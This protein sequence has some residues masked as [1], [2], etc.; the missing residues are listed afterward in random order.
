MPRS[1]SST[2]ST[3]DAT[4]SDATDSDSGTSETLSPRIEEEADE[5]RKESRT[6]VSKT[7]TRHETIEKFAKSLG[8]QGDPGADSK[9]AAGKF[10][11]NHYEANLKLAD[12][13]TKCLSIAARSRLPL[14]LDLA[15]EFHAKRAAVEKELRDGD[16]DGSHL[17]SLIYKIQENVIQL[18]NA[19]VALLLPGGVL[20]TGKDERARLIALEDAEISMVVSLQLSKI[21]DTFVVQLCPGAMHTKVVDNIRSMLTQAA[22]DAEDLITGATAAQKS[23]ILKEVSRKIG[24]G[25]RNRFIPARSTLKAMLQLFNHLLNPK[26]LAAVG[27]T[28]FSA[29]AGKA[30]HDE[31]QRV[32]SERKKLEAAAKAPWYSRFTRK[33]PEPVDVT[34]TST[35]EEDSP[36]LS[37]KD[38]LRLGMESYKNKIENVAS[39]H[40]DTAR[41]ALRRAKKSALLRSGFR[42]RPVSDTD[43]TATS[44]GSDTSSSES[45]GSESE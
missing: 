7:Q 15:G 29:F 21:L 12:S 5:A 17:A 28:A 23:R 1:R 38:A 20:D 18:V 9:T 24:K 8:L 10:I 25:S 44:S 6:I 45:S 31:G 30:V 22:R 3:T 2:S 42:R 32:H 14:L 34:P 11:W 33:T 35:D 37:T 27:L 16:F 19:E 26:V 40:V 41:E 43:T 4:D 36:P 13:L 39:P